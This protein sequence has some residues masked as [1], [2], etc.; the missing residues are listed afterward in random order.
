MIDRNLLIFWGIKIW[1]AIVGR[2][3]M[4]SKGSK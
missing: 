4:R 3:C 1:L 2:T